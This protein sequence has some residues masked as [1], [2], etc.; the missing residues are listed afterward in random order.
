MQVSRAPSSTSFAPTTTAS[1]STSDAACG[2][3]VLFT[4]GGSRSNPQPQV[5]ARH[6]SN[7]IVRPR[8]VHATAAMKSGAPGVCMWEAKILMLINT[9]THKQARAHT[10]AHTA[11]AIVSKPVQA[12]TRMRAQAMVSQSTRMRTQAMVS[13]S[14]RMRTQAMVSQ[15]IRMR[16]QAMVSQSTRMRAQAMVS[17]STRMR[18]QAMVSQSQST[19]MRTQA[20]VS[21]STALMRS[22]M[23]ASG[24]RFTM[25]LA[26]PLAHDPS[27]RAA[28]E[29]DALALDAED[30]W[31]VLAPPPGQPHSSRAGRT[32]PL[33]PPHQEQQGGVAWGPTGPVV[34]AKDG[35][36]ASML[37]FSGHVEVHGLADYLL[38]VQGFR[39]MQQVRGGAAYAPHGRA[40]LHI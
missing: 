6:C 10:H 33:Q 26:R 19:R 40:H 20:M 28:L 38:E 34:L 17:Q 35:T 21:Q 37:L 16:T 12:S 15:S 14:T 29:A 9:H 30:D 25:P 36:P 18:A 39:G 4:P 1:S 23:V 11:C 3:V 5:C 24:L 13:Q 31:A 27:R 2:T 8:C 22:K 7:E 32:H